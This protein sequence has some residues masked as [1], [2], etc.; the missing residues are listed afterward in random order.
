M[1]NNKSNF[2]QLIRVRVLLLLLLYFLLIIYYY[3]IITSSSPLCSL[4]I[5]VKNI[6]KYLLSS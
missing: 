5:S 6:I 2:N 1:N 4:I 3:I